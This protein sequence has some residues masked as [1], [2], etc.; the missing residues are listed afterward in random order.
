M[1]RWD[2]VLA[3]MSVGSGVRDPIQASWRRCLSWGLEPDHHGDLPYHQDLDDP[4]D[5]VAA[6]N[7][8][9]KHLEARLSGT[10]TV[11]FLSDSQARLLDRRVD[12]PSINRILDTTGLARGFEIA[13]ELIG[14]NGVGTA[15]ATRRPAFICGHEHFTE[16]WRDVACAGAPIRHPLSGHVIGVFDLTCLLGAH[17]DS[18]MLTMALEAA[19]GIEQQLL[20]RAASREQALLQT[21]QDAWTKTGNGSATDRLNRY[22]QRILQERAAELISSGRPG[23][24][25]VQLSG[26]C[27]AVLLCRPV[28]SPSGVTG[29]AVWATM[30]PGVVH[31]L[32]PTAPEAVPPVTASGRPDVLTTSPVTHP[33]VTGPAPEPSARTQPQPLLAVLAVGQPGYVHLAAKARQQLGL[34]YDTNARVGTTLDVTRTAEELTE[35]TVPRFADFAAVDLPPAVP[36]GEEPIHAVGGPVERVAITGVRE[37]SHLYAVGDL[38]TY[39]TSTPQGRS[40]ISEDPVLVPELARAD[41]WISHDPVRGEKVLAAGVHSLITVPMRARGTLLGVVSFYRSRPEPFEEDDLSLAEELVGHAALC[42]DNARRYTREHTVALALQRSLLPHGLPAQRAVEAAHRY[43]PARSGVGGDWF[44]VIPLS[45]ARVALVVGDVVGH[46]LHAA[47]TMGRLRTAIHTFCSLD[48]AP[49]ELLTH[50]DDLVLRLQEEAETGS[51]EIIG[52]SCVY[53][54]YD[55]AT[56]RCILARAGHP[57]PA[58]VLPDGTVEYLEVPAGPPLGLG[59]LPFETVEIEI[60]AAD[61][62]LVLYTDG[63]I[64]HLGGRDAGLG[65]DQLHRVLA[66]P[67]RTP[68]QTCQALDALLSDQP[69]DDIAVLVARTKGLDADQIATWDVPAAPAVVSHIRT[70]VIAQLTRWHLQETFATELIVSELV[71]NAIRYGAEPITLRLLRPT[72]HTL[73]CEVSDSSSTSPHLR[74]ARTTDEGGRGLYLV[75]HLVQRW[76]T[77]YDPHGKVIWTEQPLP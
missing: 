56:R 76:G 21:F 50:L 8:I 24:A 48:L 66:H 61:S 64:E 36:L 57:P 30:P 9:I 10:G 32:T 38:V 65:I 72:D 33:T 67:D 26:G 3:D 73:I 59:G 60:E 31:R 34:L 41:G 12:D 13:E 71:T 53:A 51:K 69:T 5:L 28:T 29:F 20:Q 18:S 4:D 39:S 49:D 37:D 63:L 35:V 40:L 15:L 14:T 42:I 6:A 75:A 25:E 11:A 77:R 27:T 74:N 47:V 70:D 43:L 55:P 17:R 2:D 62:C 54:V 58:L 45:G 52:A 23:L 7:T 1:T 22:D 68:E 19:R 44:D 46:G 16:E